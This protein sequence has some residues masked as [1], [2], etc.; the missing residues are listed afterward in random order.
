MVRH[1]LLFREPAPSSIIEAEL[2]GDGEP[3]KPDDSDDGGDGGEGSDTAESWEDVLMEDEDD[4]ALTAGMDT[5]M[6]DSDFFN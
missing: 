3:S 6:S 1:D 5:G 2:N 4:S